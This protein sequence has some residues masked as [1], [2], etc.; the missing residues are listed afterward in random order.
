MMEGHHPPQCV[1]GA[2]W[3]TMTGHNAS[4]HPFL[5]E[6]CDFDAFM[7]NGN[8]EWTPVLWCIAALVQR[9]SL[10]R[11]IDA[12]LMSYLANTFM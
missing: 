5:V 8:G 1:L 3:T 2:L 12:A 4:Q 6:F 9:L 7:C 10:Y 11:S